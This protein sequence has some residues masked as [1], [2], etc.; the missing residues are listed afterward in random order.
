MAKD[1]WETTADKVD[2]NA[3][4]GKFVK[5]EDDEDLIVCAFLGAPLAR[6]LFFDKKQETYVPFTE[7]HAKRKDRMTLRIAFNVY[8]IKEGNGEDVNEVAN[9]EVRILEVS[10][11]TYKS[12]MKMRKKYGFEK[13]YFEVQRH[14]KKRDTKTTYSITPDEDIEADDLEAIKGLDLFDLDKEVGGSDGDEKDEFDSY[15]EKKKSKGKS[16]KSKKADDGD[17]S[18]DTD[19]AAQLVARLRKVPK[20]KLQAFLTKFGIGKVKT[21]KKKDLDAALAFVD[22]LEGKGS[23]D[24]EEDPFA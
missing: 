13:Y 24:E 7:E 19:D 8:V 14:G 12:V 22:E 2:E 5:L 9:P 15:D 6:E 23:D 3:S 20:D 18:I 1:P 16:G 11:Q 10:S 21:L 4:G 17:D